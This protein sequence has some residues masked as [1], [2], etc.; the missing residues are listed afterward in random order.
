MSPLQCQNAPVIDCTR[1]LDSDLARAR[2]ARTPGNET[3]ALAD[4]NL[5][6]LARAAPSQDS[7]PPQKL[8][9]DSELG[10]AAALTTSTR[11][12]EIWNAAR[13]R[14]VIR[15]SESAWPGPGD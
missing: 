14:V 12:D 6:A 15:Q 11:Q 1:Y 8:K 4:R 13:L 5:P 7:E 10:T 9:P 2:G 3:P